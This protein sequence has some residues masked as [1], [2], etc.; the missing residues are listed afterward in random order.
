MTAS[1]TRRLRFWLTGRFERNGKAGAGVFESKSAEHL[2]CLCLKGVKS[3]SV[4]ILRRLR[5]LGTVP[6]TAMRTFTPSA[7]VSKHS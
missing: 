3:V 1:W 4:R 5:A 6:G 7:T 2:P